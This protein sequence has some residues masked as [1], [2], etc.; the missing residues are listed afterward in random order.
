[1]NFFSPGSIDQGQPTGFKS[2]LNR[3][4]FGVVLVNPATPL[5]WELNGQKASASNSLS[6]CTG[7][8]IDTAIGEIRGELDDIAV[9]I[10]QLTIDAAEVLASADSAGASANLGKKRRRRGQATVARDR[11]DAERAEAKAQ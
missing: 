10:A 1:M 4:S 2:G 6:V 8:C 3:G 9:Q 7:E 11:A 5:V